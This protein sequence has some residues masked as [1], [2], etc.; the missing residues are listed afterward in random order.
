MLG[1]LMTGFLPD[2][3]ILIE[4]FGS[5]FNIPKALMIIGALAC[6]IVPYLI[7]SLNSAVIFS[8]LVF[9]DDIRNYGSKNAG[10]TNMFRVYGKKGGLLTLAGDVLKSF[11]AVFFG[12]FIFGSLWGGAYVAGFFCVIGHIFPIYF[13]FKGGKGVLA[14]AIIILCTCP[15]VFIILILLFALITVASRYVSLGSVTCA[16][17]YPMIL[18]AFIRNLHG[19]IV[20][21][22]IFS[23]MLAALVVIMH[24]SNINRLFKGEENKV[25][26]GRKDK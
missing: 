14:S 26:L 16:F 19:I 21:P 20:I 4:S 22:V 17:F 23:V 1:F 18:Y 5:L 8:K 13:K 15:I 10:M 11:I 6:I 12:A 2:N 25:Y 3:G 7:G 9:R 24:K